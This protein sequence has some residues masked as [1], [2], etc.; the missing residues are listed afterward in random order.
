MGFSCYDRSRKTSF[1]CS[2]VGF[3]FRS[4]E[5]WILEEL[6]CIF[7]VFAGQEKHNICITYF[8]VELLRIDV[9]MYL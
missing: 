5:K 6:G 8:I 9:E 4:Q 1:N 3:L 7:Y 2:E